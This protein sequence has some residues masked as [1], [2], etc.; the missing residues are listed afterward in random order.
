MLVYKRVFPLYPVPPN[1]QIMMGLRKARIVLDVI[2]DCQR[3]S[4]PCGPQSACHR[5]ANSLQLRNLYNPSSKTTVSAIIWMDI[6]VK[7]SKCL[8]Y[9][10]SRVAQLPPVNP[11]A[12]RVLVWRAHECTESPHVGVDRQFILVKIL[13]LCVVRIFW[14]RITINRMTLGNLL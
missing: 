9:S 12:L 1:F 2:E 5:F 8:L 7:L 14:C 11:R 3:Q 13:S 4:G 6:I 10:F